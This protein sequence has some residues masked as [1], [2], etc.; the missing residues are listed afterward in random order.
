MFFVFF[1]KTMKFEREA[2]NTFREIEKSKTNLNNEF[3]FSLKFTT[4]E[5]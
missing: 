2:S 3:F 4:A 1:V 5:Q